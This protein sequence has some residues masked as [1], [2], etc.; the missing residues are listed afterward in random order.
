M[1]VGSH[2]SVSD[3]STVSLQNYH[4]KLIKE[5]KSPNTINNRLAA[6]EAMYNW[7]LDNEI[8]DQSPRRLSIGNKTEKQATDYDSQSPT[9]HSQ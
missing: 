7:A 1:F 6:V 3:I 8:I 4:K 5:G 9:C 2:R